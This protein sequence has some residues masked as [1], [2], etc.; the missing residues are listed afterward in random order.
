M[1][2]V[3]K[4]ADVLTKAQKE[5][6]LHALGLDLARAE[7][8]TRDYY[9]TRGDDLDACALV[10]AGLFVSCGARDWLCGDTTFRVTEA[11]KTEGRRIWAEDRPKLTRGQRRYRDWL[12]ADC[13]L[14]FGEWLKQTGG[15]DG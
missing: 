9:L 10:A 6:L 15:Q 2:L 7:A 14:R 1:D 12:R 11:G 13:G 5:M 8:P 4:M 3:V